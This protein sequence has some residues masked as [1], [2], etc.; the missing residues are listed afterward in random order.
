MRE[1]KLFELG[2]E[3]H[4]FTAIGRCPRTGR[5]G[6]SISTGEMAVA[7][8]CIYVK[9]NVGA[10]ATQSRTNPLL[11]PF[12]IQ[13]MEL[14]YP[15]NRA[16]AE[17]EASDPHIEY[18]QLGIVDR[19]GGTAVRTGSRNA[20]WNGHLTGDGWITMGNGIVGE[21][22]VKAMAKAME[23]SAEEEIEVRLMKAVGAGTDAGGQPNGQRSAGI[24]VY[25]N[26]GFTIINLRVDDSDTPMADLWK[27]FDKFQPML[28]Y[29]KERPF[30]PTIGAATE[31]AAARAK[32]L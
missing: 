2:T 10:V 31:W 13:L 3:T 19:W 21:G 28:D 15:A 25:E 6:I 29:Y 5:L 18:R 30:D 1:L 24:L 11:G 27:L 26:E 8:R 14:G 12:A 16:L 4:T 9:S 22:V 7:G 20:D 32:K 17:L 23:E